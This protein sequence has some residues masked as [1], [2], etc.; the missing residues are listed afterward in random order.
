MPI[1]QIHGNNQNIF[2]QIMSLVVTVSIGVRW[3][4]YLNVDP[5]AL[6]TYNMPMCWSIFFK[7]IPLQRR[8][9]QYKLFLDVLSAHPSPTARYYIAQ[10]KRVLRSK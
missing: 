1:W 4:I 5:L 8:H 9:L 10:L 6:I 3:Q 2:L 7:I